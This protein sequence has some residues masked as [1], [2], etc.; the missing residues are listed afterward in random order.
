MYCGLA[1]WSARAWHTTVTHAN[2]LY[3][4]GGTPLNN[5]VRYVCVYKGEGSR[6]VCFYL[7]IYCFICCVLKSYDYIMYVYRCGDWTVLYG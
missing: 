2:Q 7:Y 6:F 1:Q 4:M 5:E 3:V